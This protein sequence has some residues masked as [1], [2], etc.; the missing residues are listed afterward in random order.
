MLCPLRWVGGKRRQASVI[1]PLLGRHAAY[2]ETCCGGAAVFWAK[3][4]EASSCEILNDTDGELI[5]FYYV[6]HKAGRRLATEVNA[7]PY[8][9]ALFG[10]QLRARPRGAFRRAT[11]FWYLNRVAFGAKR[12][13]SSFGVRATGRAMVL[14]D[15][16]LKNLDAVMERLRGVVFEAV[17][18]ARLLEL[19]DRSTTLFYVDPPYWGTAQPYACQ[20]ADDD[21]ARLAAALAKVKGRWLLSYN[22]CRRVRRLYSGYHVRRLDVRYTIGCNSASQA[23]EQAGEVLISN[24]PFHPET[25]RLMSS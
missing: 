19:Y 9:R 23:A 1:L 12:R 18:V 13:G 11:R 3:P 4:R 22:D 7:M 20:F 8:S 17:D 25:R 6:L 15:A 21:H 5:N 14:H 24:R 10:K 2:C 16:L